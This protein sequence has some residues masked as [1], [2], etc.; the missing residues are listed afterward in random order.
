MNYELGIMENLEEIEGRPQECQSARCP[1]YWLHERESGLARVCPLIESGYAR[2]DL[3]R[4]AS[5]GELLTECENATT[6]LL[7]DLDE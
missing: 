5:E 7:A 2:E 6:V 3:Q 4:L 1:N